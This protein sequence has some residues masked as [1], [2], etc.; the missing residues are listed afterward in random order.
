MELLT[1][2]RPYAKAAFLYAMEHACTDGWEQMLETM[3]NIVSDQKIR[4]LLARPDVTSEQR[5]NYLTQI[6]GNEVDEPG[7]C[8]IKILSENKRLSLLPWIAQQFSKFK[9]SHQREVDVIISSASPLSEAQL[10]KLNEKLALRLE[11]TVKIQT[12]IDPL[13]IGGLKICAGDWIYDGSLKAKLD[14]LTST[15]AT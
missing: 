9:Q 7:A 2:A 5:V 3:S 10:S 12:I 14:Q 11:Q 1:C 15:V 13:L 8:F 4:Q 6:L